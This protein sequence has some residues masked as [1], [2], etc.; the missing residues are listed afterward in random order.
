M[1]ERL[2]LERRPVNLPLGRFGDNRAPQQ[3][4]TGRIPS[5]ATAAKRQ[6]ASNSEDQCEFGFA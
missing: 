3:N 4:V 2:A 6:A 5:A 1:V